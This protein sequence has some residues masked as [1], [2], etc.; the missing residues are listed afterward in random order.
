M[1]LRHFILSHIFFILY[2]SHGLTGMNCF[3]RGFSGDLV[4]AIVE[5]EPLFVK[6]FTP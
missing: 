2:Y 6:Q 5:T 3:E 1:F 4:V